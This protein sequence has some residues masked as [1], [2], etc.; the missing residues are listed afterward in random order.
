MFNL[1][2]MINYEKKYE[3]IIV[4]LIKNYFHELENLDIR[5]KEVEN[6]SFYAQA[7]HKRKYFLIEINKK[8][9]KWKIK[10]IT[11]MLGH[12]LGHLIVYRKVGYILTKI[13]DFLE[14]RFRYFKALQ[15]R[16]ADKAAIEHGL[17]KLF[18]ETRE[19]FKKNKGKKKSI[20]LILLILYILLIIADYNNVFKL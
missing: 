6:V 2:Y 4:K 12:E 11:S 15:E 13:S 19:R 18:L 14:S 8:V 16:S 9:R 10:D 7:L 3:T 17:G 20:Y 5:I 1:K